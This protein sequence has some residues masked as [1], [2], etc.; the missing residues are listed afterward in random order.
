MD[1][2]SVKG[3]GNTITKIAGW[4]TIVLRFDLRAGRS[5]S[6]KLKNVLHLPTAGNCLLSILK[7]VESGGYAEFIGKQMSL[8]VKG[9]KVLGTGQLDHGL[10]I[11]KA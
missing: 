5:T 11:L 1:N 9:G 4:G 10:Y 6:H 8:K 2:T 7:L 3:V